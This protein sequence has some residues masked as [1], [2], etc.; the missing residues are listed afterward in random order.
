MDLP[1]TAE[2]SPPAV[3]STDRGSFG[4]STSI[5]PPFRFNLETGVTAAWRDREGAERQ[6]INGPEVLAR[7]GL[8]EDRLE[9]R[10][11]WSGYVD[12]REDAAGGARTTADGLADVI[13]GLKLKCLD[14][15]GWVPRTVLIAQTYLGTGN[16]EVTGGV[17]PTVKAAFSWD[18]GDGWALLGNAGVSWPSDSEDHFTQGLGSIL[19]SY[20]IAEETTL[21]AEYYA[22]F[23]IARDDDAA[24]AVDFGVWQRL[25]PSIQ[26][27]A[28]VGFGLNDA[29]DDV[30]IGAGI[31]FLF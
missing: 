16:A 10:A 15:D 17:D 11:I 5:M 12:S 25:G 6:V 14:Q 7:M 27:D 8:L 20:A 19:V 2:A 1:N 24:H 9:F 29:A 26:L 21:F 13:L 18:L 22:T 30:L 31:S 23:P 28:R 4:D 3:I